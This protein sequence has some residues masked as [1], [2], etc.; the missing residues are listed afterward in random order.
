MKLDEKKKIESLLKQY[1]RMLEVM[2]RFLTNQS[3]LESIFSENYL[4]D[5]QKQSLVLVLHYLLYCR[6]LPWL[7]L[8]IT[9]AKVAT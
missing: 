6:E 3:G 7:I 4:W 9:I 1:D 5:F 8:Q 2:W